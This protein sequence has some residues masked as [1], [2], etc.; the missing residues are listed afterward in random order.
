MGRGFFMASGAQ[1]EPERQGARS[2]GRLIARLDALVAPVERFFAYVSSLFIFGLMMIGVVQIVSRKIFNAPIFGY[3]DLVELAMTT[4]AFLAVA[5]TERAG[6]HVRVE[7]LVG[8]LR[9]RA[10][11]ALEL[12]GVMIALFVVGVLIYYGYTHTVRAYAFGDSTIDA[13][14]P[15]WPSKALVPIAFS[16]LWLRLLIELYGYLRLL[17]RP[18]EE[19]VGVPVIADLQTLAQREASVETVE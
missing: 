9:G 5:Y 18:D 7:L 14:Y 8:R 2:N 13:E 3:I 15:W 4:F 17:A 10:L 16:L 1:M 6:G 11:W 12:M 19:P